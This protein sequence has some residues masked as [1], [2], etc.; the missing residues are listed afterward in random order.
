[1]GGG[2][3]VAAQLGGVGSFSAGSAFNAVLALEGGGA[4]EALVG[5][6]KRGISSVA[7]LMPAWPVGVVQ[8]GECPAPDLSLTSLGVGLMLEYHREA[9]PA[10][11]TG[12]SCSLAAS[13]AMSVMLSGA[14]KS[15]KSRKSPLGRSSFS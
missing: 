13:A 2:F 11:V 14:L 15:F 8:V 6:Q 7:L 1:M 12:R 10:A 3:Y 4:W 9:I 5:L